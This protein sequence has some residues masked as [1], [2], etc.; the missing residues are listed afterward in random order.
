V[1]SIGRRDPA[2]DHLAGLDIHIV[3]RQLRPMN[4]DATHHRHD[5]LPA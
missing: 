2:P 1:F 3:E 5:D 4:I